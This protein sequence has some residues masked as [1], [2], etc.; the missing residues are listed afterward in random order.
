ME[1][2]PGVFAIRHEELDLTT[3]LVVGDGACLVIDTTGDHV[4]GA[5]LAKQI[6][7]ITPHP[8]QVVYTH[9]HFDH[10]YG[11]SAFMPCD[12]WAHVN[13]RFDVGEQAKWVRKYRE[14]GK[15]EIADAIE[16]TEVIRPTQLLVRDDVLSVGGRT[17]ALHHFG[18]GH[19]FSDVVVHV[20]DAGVVFAGDLIE[21]PEF[22][23]ESFGD[24]DVTQW[25][26]ALEALLALDPR[27]VVPGHGEPVDKDFVAKQREILAEI[28]TAGWTS[29]Q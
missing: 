19:S 22:I 1:V 26:A 28:V 29:P 24:G 20:P 25:P 4:Q 5:A 3:G 10:Y 7:E 16:H 6:R 14:D 12:V 13:F 15:P 11:T 27:V 18:P 17:V 23:E 21:H 8:W 9:A 2:G